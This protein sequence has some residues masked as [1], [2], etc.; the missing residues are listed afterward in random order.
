MMKRSGFVRLTAAA[1]TSTPF[2]LG[3]AAVATAFSKYDITKDKDKFIPEVI[4]DAKFK[5][6]G[7]LYG[8]NGNVYWAVVDPAKHPLYVWEKAGTTD[9]DSTAKGLNAV[10]F[11]NGPLM[12]LAVSPK[13]YGPVFGKKYNINDP[14]GNNL[15]KWLYLLGRKTPGAGGV[16]FSD[17]VIAKADKATVAGYDEVII[18]L[19]PV[20]INKK[21]L[22]TKKSDPNYNESFANFMVHSSTIVT[23][24]LAKAQATEENPTKGVIVV[25]G[26]RTGKIHVIEALVSIGVDDAVATD[27][28]ESVLLGERAEAWIEP[29]TYKQIWQKYGFCCI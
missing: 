14:G 29:A 1:V 23:W 24:S 7:F 10:A 5:A 2:L 9:Y 22:G 25:A 28:N 11:S 17:Y 15:D 4:A 26:D 27:G 3:R 20:I 6:Q 16:A 8:H 13:P 19:Y 21:E 18:G 12:T